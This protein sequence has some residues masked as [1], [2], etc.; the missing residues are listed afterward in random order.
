MSRWHTTEWD[1]LPEN[2]FQPR[3]FGSWGGMT[4]EGGG[5]GGSAPDPN[6]GMIASA[7][8]SERVGMR[9]LD[10]QQEYM[11]W[12][13]DFYESLRPTLERAAQQEYEIANENRQRAKEYAEFERSTFRPLEADLVRDA[14][15]FSTVSK[16]EQLASQ[17]ASDVNQ[18]YAVARDQNNRALTRMGINPNSSRF[19]ALNQQLA[20]RQA[21]DSAGAMTKARNDA[22][23]M[24]FARRMDAA[25]LGR[26]LASNASTAYGVSLNA[27]NQGSNTNLAS[28]N[29]M[30][31]AY[32]QGS[33]MLGQAT[34]A[35]GTAGNIYGQ[36][37]NA[38][39]QG[40]QAKQSAIGD[41][42]GA[43]GTGIGMWAGGG[44]KRADGGAIKLKDGGSPRGLRKRG[45]VTGPGGPVDDLV[46]AMLS[47]GEYV[48]PA[49]TVEQVGVKTLDKLVK[50]THTPAAVQRKR[51]ALKGKK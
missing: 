17:A 35:Y 2:A 42:Y 10:L 39:M 30:S 12:S 19:A 22:E 21:A 24:G 33:Q 36:D 47:N 26:N 14:R 15:E 50:K 3:G 1:L 27:S 16:Q 38:R 48:L 8:A 34:N 40:Y 25:S 13:K 9:A 43:L 37:F 32:G 5:K 23:N 18:G 7:Q 28:G 49:D 41:F 45:K 31:S 6:P 11:N 4:L 44:F 46:P 20:T 29:F 51:K